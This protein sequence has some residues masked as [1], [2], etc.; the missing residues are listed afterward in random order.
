MRRDGSFLAAIQEVSMPFRD[1]MLGQVR[2]S[3]VRAV[4]LPRREQFFPSPA[5]WRSE[6]I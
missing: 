5:D 4:D 3:S 2:P 6:V 1:A